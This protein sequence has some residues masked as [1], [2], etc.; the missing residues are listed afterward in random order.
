MLT[1]HYANMKTLQ[2]TTAVVSPS[3]VSSYYIDVAVRYGTTG[4]F[5]ILATNIEVNPDGTLVNPLGI[6]VDDS[7]GED[8]QLKITY[9]DCPEIPY[10]EIINI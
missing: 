1:E 4:P 2:L 7:L 10:Y 6:N 5:T 3:T 9:T 8:I